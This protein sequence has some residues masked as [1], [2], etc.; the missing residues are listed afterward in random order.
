MDVSVTE[1]P[2]PAVSLAYVRERYGSQLTPQGDT[3]EQRAV[4]VATIARRIAQDAYLRPDGHDMQTH[5]TL[6][7]GVTVQALR[8]E[9][10]AILYEAVER[11]HTSFEDIRN[12]TNL[13]VAQLVTERTH[14]LRL[15]YEYRV[16]ARRVRLQE[17]GEDLSIL[18]LAELVAG[19][20]M[21][22]W[23]LANSKAPE[24]DI[25]VYRCA[26]TL[27][28]D[29]TAMS[30]LGHRPGLRRYV[31]MLSSGLGGLLHAAE[32][33]HKSRSSRNRI[34]KNPATRK[35]GSRGKRPPG[36]AASRVRKRT[37]DR[38]GRNPGAD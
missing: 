22:K 15:P 20:Q 19:A 36:A 25:A 34:L 31:D 12:L 18:A 14:D 17:A 3:A 21:A 32:V 33:K 28:E 1:L 2:P 6:S 11:S 38:R 16:N 7:A 26:E 37:G 35:D 5:F 27:Y 29:L 9:H 8:L 30:Q 4:R 13:E 24:T 10:A 23:Q